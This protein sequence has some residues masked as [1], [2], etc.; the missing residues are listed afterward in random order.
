MSA[1]K[2]EIQKLR[3]RVMEKDFSRMNDRQKEAVFST[4]GPLLVLAGAGSG[5]TTV[6]VNRIA[7]IVRYGQAYSSSLVSDTISQE[8]VEACK[9]YM[10][11]VELENAVRE[12]LA[13]SPC[14]AWRVMAITFTNKAAG[15]LKDRLVQM[16]G[17][18]GG[19]VWASTFHASCARMLRRDGD[20]LG[21][22]SHFT[23]YDTDDSRRLMKEVLRDLEISEKLLSPKGALAEISRAKD[24]LTLPQEF[25]ECAGDDYRLKQVARAY[26]L[27]QARL[28]DADAMDFD[29]LI[30]NTVR[31]FEK[32]P[33]V[34]EYY[35]NR[36]RYLM[37]D[38]YQDTNHAQYR[39]VSLLAQRSGN[40]CVVGDDDQSIYKF[41]GATI[42]NILNFEEDFPGAKVI[43]LEENYRS[44]QNILDAANAVIKN[45]RERKGKTLWTAAGPGEKITL[46]LASDERDEADYIARTI[47]DGVEQGRKFSDYA[48]LYRMNSQSQALERMFARQGI[49]HRIIGGTRFFDRKEVRDMIAYLNVI[50]NPSDEVRLRRIVNVPK[51]GIGDR[52]VE[53]AS[54]IGRQVGESLYSVFTHPGDFPAIARAAK[55]V[56]AFTQVMDEF[57]EKNREGMLPS[58]LY[59]ELVER[60]RYK[61]YLEED[62]P[63]KAE[64]RLENVAELSTMLQRYEEEAGDGASLSSFLE[65]VALYTDIDNYDQSADSTVMMTIHSAKG[66]EFPVVFL[67]GWEEG[68]FPGMSVIYNPEEVEEERRLAYVAIT[69]AREQ[70]YICH[71]ESRMLFGTTT[72]NRLSR[73]AGEIP[74]ELIQQT[75]SGGWM[76]T[77][78][79]GGAALGSAPRGTAQ[80]AQ[81][82]RMPQMPQPGKT[83][84]VKPVFT[85]QP[86]KPVPA[87]TYQVGDTVRHKTFGQG[88]ILSATKMAN[89][90]L[91]EIAFDKVGT[92]KLFANYGRLEKL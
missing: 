57:I 64:E 70:L 61:A 60:L 13:V 18:S 28:A 27:Y 11:D 23:I 29:D 20:R 91:L 83:A 55:K 10:L 74:Q 46:H 54:Q 88:L 41:R 75:R 76:R 67:P 66:L 1:T 89:D 72:H 16:L 85:P 79:P 77:S 35:Q 63:D 86:V 44:T 7:N 21:F 31:M 6:L 65:E 37:V 26:R 48:V 40:L 56:A 47:L 62:D 92:K 42:E 4:E 43:R 14:P 53:L 39:F 3:M 36:F 25:E 80:L 50:N 82:S 59:S 32:C 51:R 34:L 90:T 12:R 58:Q 33:D 2:Q 8:D 30:V 69:R 15:E 38:E 19:E 87:G 45:N 84:A 73:F 5:K 52:T 81:P 78:V 22:T 24:E 71:A 17:D 49:P 9:A 68:V